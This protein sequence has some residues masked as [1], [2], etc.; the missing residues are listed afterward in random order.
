MSSDYNYDAEGQ[1]YPFFILTIAGLIT[2]PLTYNVFKADTNVEAAAPPAKYNYKTDDEDLIQESKRKAKRRERKVKRMLAAT[3]GYLVMAGMVYLIIVTARTTPRI[4]DPYSILGVSSVCLALA[5]PSSDCTCLRSAYERQKFADLKLQSADE[6]TLKKFYNKLSLKYHPDKAV[7]DASLNETLETINDRW[8][9]MTKAYKALTD[10]EVRNNYLQY[11]HPDGK[12]SFSM[13][14]ALPKFIVQEGSGKYVLL[15]YG[16]LL[17]VIL[18]YGVG[19][20]WYGTQ[21]LTKDKVLVGSANKLVQ[22]FKE[23]ISEG[24]IIAAISTG[25]EFQDLL[26]GSRADAGA[27]KVEKKITAIATLSDADRTALKEIEDPVRRKVLSLLWAYLY[28]VDLDDVALRKEKIEA[29]PIAIHLNNSMTSITLGFQIV[30]PLLASYH[31]T[32]NLIQAIPPDASPMLQLPH[33]TPK[34]VESIQSAHSK[35]RLSIQKFM[36]LPA[37]IRR[38]LASDLSDSQYASAMHVASQIPHLRVAKAFFKVMGERVVTPSSLVQ[39]VV[40]AR[41]IPLGSTDI[42]EVNELD[43]EDVDPDEDDLEGLTGR[44]P[45]RNKRQKTVDGQIIEADSKPVQPPLAFSPYYP[46]DHS[47]RW[48]I[49]LADSRAG[50]IAVPPFTFSSFDKPIVD[51]EGR[52]TYDMQ[53]LKCQFQAPPM[54]GQYA[55]AMHLI[56]DSYIGFDTKMDVVLDVKPVGEAVQEEI[57]DEISEPDEGTRSILPIPYLAVG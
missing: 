40:K 43:L 14:I 17:G 20:W 26:K 31:T 38:S 49:F 25:Q 57:E 24:G 10:E 37:Q 23:D 35:D 45:P 28:R 1:F 21:A 29:A 19:Q 12:Q 13:G 6:K 51:S 8:V 50:R 42:P 54:A 34:I 27:A 7:P 4:Y 32:Q 39:L 16:I 41:F 2:L 15:L 30:A 22:E 52:P 5:F 55:F 47:P 48:H 44:K 36:S 18:P 11:G 46:R 33:F 9:E 53:T 3:L 56:C